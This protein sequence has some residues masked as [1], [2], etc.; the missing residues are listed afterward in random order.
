L[1]QKRGSAATVAEAYQRALAIDASLSDPGSARSDWFN[2]GQFLRRQHQPERLVFA[3]FLHA[4]ELM[5]TT[6]GAELSTIVQA[7][8]ESEMHLGRQAAAVRRSSGLVTKETLDLRASS[9][10]RPG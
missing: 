10:S 7:R 6:P 9:F 5:S 1:Q 3:C 2:Y 4:E 8:A